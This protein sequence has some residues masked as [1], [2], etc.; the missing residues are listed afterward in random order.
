MK[1]QLNNSN[2]I[3]L[4]PKFGIYIHIP[5]CEKICNYCDFYKIQ[6]QNTKE[7]KQYFIKVK[8]HLIEWL[9]FYNIPQLISIYFGGGTPGLFDEEYANILNILKVFITPKVEITLETNPENI[10]ENKLKIWKNLGFN[11]LSIGIQ[12]FNYNG[13]KFLTRTH[14]SANA[15]QKIKLSQKYFNNINVDLIYAWP[16]QT[17]KIFIQ[18]LNTVITLKIPHISLYEL[19]YH[20]NTTLWNKIAKGIITPMEDNNIFELYRQAC[21]ILKT[22]KYIHEEISNWAK[23]NFLALHNTLYWNTNYVIAVGPSAHGFV[24]S[25]KIYGL[26][27]AYPSNLKNFL[28]SNPIN[29]PKTYKELIIDKRNIDSFFIEYISCALRTHTG[30][31]LDFV[32]KIFNKT[33]HISPFIHQ[34]LKNKQ[35]RLSQTSLQLNEIEFFKENSWSLKILECFK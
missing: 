14:K 21:K 19:S 27:Y 9:N 8:E 29:I 7:I 15:I 10:T 5:F 13:L 31:N 1:N 20:K 2:L 26:R 32:K 16:Q 18:D 12:T 34:A 3:Y 17:P 11:R 22:K 33:L 4:K 23:K 35:I 30:I 6:L 25:D 28:K 24:P